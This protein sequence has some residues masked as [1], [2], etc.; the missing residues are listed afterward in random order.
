ML[1]KIKLIIFDLDGTLVD[2]SVDIANAMNYAIAPYGLDEISVERAKQMVGE[3]VTRL[4]EKMV[5]EERAEIRPA[6]LER[7]I[8]YYSDH[9]ADFTLPYPGVVEALEGLQNYKKVVLSNK[10]EGHS[11]RL[12]DMLGLSRFFDAVLGSDSVEERK[13]S[14]KPVFQILRMFSVAPEEAVIVG[15]SGFDIEAG[16]TAGVKTVAVT[17]GFRAVEFLREA[18]VLIDDMRELKLKLEEFQGKKA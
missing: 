3:G 14:P 1:H 12:L 7:F 9:L 16:R 13:P 18:D 5:A 6:V 15:D 10:R 8:Q 17:Y 2:S 11:K 4:I